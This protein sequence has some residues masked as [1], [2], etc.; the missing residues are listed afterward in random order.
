MA[1][2]TDPFI[3]HTVR[4]WFST[5]RQTADVSVFS[6]SGIT[7]NTL[8]QS[9]YC[10]HLMSDPEG[11]SASMSK[12]ARKYRNGLLHKL[13]FLINWHHSHRKEYGRPEL[14]DLI[15]LQPAESGDPAFLIAPRGGPE[16][17][18]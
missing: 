13:P 14:L 4:E 7:S 6:I 8:S 5:R 2:P 16:Q 17:G 9:G 10:D 15:E 11:S 18:I 12:V 1:E 3:H